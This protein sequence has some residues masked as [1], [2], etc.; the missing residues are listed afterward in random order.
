MTSQ[1][2][3][4]PDCKSV[5]RPAKPV[6]DGKQVKCPKCGKIFT[7]PGLLDDDESPRKK[8]SSKKKGKVVVKKASSPPPAPKPADDDDD[9]GIYGYVSEQE[10]AEED[11]PQIE[12]APDLSIKDLRGPAQAAVVV[13]TNYILLVA[14]LCCLSDIFI[15]CVS[16][17]PMVFSDTPLLDSEWRNAL[18]SH[19]K[20]D[21]NAKQRIDGIKERKDLKDK[22]EEIVQEAESERRFWLFLMM[23]VFILMLVYNAIT[24]IG[25][26]KAQNLESRG[27]GIAS[28]IM[29]L[30]PMGAAGLGTLIGG[31]FYFTFGSWVLEEMNIYYSIGLGVLPYLAAIFI[32]VWSLRTLMSQEVI[33]GFEYIAE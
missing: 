26:V 3:T 30:L 10:R 31:V 13:P 29:T 12:Y 17:W 15:I 11:K 19:Y 22:D 4:C 23:G 9:D 18:K 1:R 25:A 33:D 21:K 2:I 27:W 6:A 8:E 32:G 7:T 28:C 16:F 24:I 20:D 5:L 14:G